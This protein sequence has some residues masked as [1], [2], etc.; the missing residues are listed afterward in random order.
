MPLNWKLDMHSSKVEVLHNNVCTTS[1]VLSLIANS[2]NPKMTL[3][4]K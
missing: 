1:F 4:R 3:I 2:I